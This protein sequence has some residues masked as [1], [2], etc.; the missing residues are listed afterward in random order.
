MPLPNVTA[1]DNDTTPLGPK[2]TRVV[3]IG[4]K[5]PVSLSGDGADVDA[6]RVPQ[7]DNG[8]FVAAVQPFIGQPISRHLIGEIEAT[9]GEFQRAAGYPF[10]SISTPPQEISDGVIRFRVIEFRTGTITVAG[11]KRED[12]NAISSRVRLAPGDRVYAPTLSADLDWLN[13]SPFRQVTAQFSPSATIGLTDLQLNAVEKKPWNIFAGY[14]NTGSVISPNRYFVGGTLGDFAGI[15]S[16]LSMQV[17]GS[18]N[19]WSSGGWPFGSKLSAD[20]GSGAIVA[21]LPL[22]ARS[23]LEITADAVGQNGPDS[24]LADS[25]QMIE[26]SGRLIT[27]LSNVAGSLPGDVSLGIEARH[28][29]RTRYFGTTA[30]DDDTQ[31][32]YQ[33]ALGWQWAWSGPQSGNVD[34]ALHVSPGRVG[35][36]QHRRSLRD[37]FDRPGD[38]RVVQL[39]DGRCG[40]AGYGRRRFRPRAEVRRSGQQWATARFRA[41]RA[42]RHG[43][44]AGLRCR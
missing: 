21:D 40:V 26:G 6:T 34:A 36:R 16:V 5:D 37:L 11:N 3:L 14:S 42:R 8:A 20:Y 38:E 23:G 9:I 15:N 30:I 1:G 10:V 31:S 39:R 33:L 29:E 35:V 27:S 2:L 24:A 12:A 7:L 44:S 32:I 43:G 28:E 18:P 19:F 22:A 41:G 13:R 25:T 17:T 4:I